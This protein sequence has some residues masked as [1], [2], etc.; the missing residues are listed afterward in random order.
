M[1]L[2]MFWVQQTMD[3]YNN[4]NNNNNSN[5]LFIYSR[6]QFNRQ[7][8]F[9]TTTTT[10]IIVIIIYLF[11]FSVQQKMVIY[12]NYNNNNNNNN[13]NAMLL[14]NF[15]WT[16]WESVQNG[17][18]KNQCKIKIAIL[19]CMFVCWGLLMATKRST[20]FHVL[21]RS[22]LYLDSITWIPSLFF[23]LTF[24]FWKVKGGLWDHLSVRLCVSPSFL[25][26]F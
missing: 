17:T 26:F 7:W 24:V 13:N 14:L 9:T 22:N 8:T 11:A 3:I 10:T 15:P 1:Y 5:N 12:N 6:S 2:F 16:V 21:S 18:N 23:S 20:V 4:N 25:L 19:G